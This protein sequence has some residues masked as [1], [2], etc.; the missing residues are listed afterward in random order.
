MP[1]FSRFLSLSS[2]LFGHVE[3]EISVLFPP[4]LLF[5][6]IVN[7]VEKVDVFSVVVCLCFVFCCNVSLPVIFFSDMLQR[8]RSQ[9]RVGTACRHLLMRRQTS[10]AACVFFMRARLYVNTR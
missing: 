6:N 10:Y 9:L 5:L 2:V 8:D 1:L 3:V 4:F 7:V